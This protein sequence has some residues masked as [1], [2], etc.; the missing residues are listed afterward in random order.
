MITTEDVEITVIRKKIKNIYLRVLPPDGRAVI[1]APLNAGDDVILRFA[2]SRAGWIR[3]QREK[4]SDRY[5]VR[6]KKYETGEEI[7]FFGTVYHLEVRTPDSS[8]RNRVEKDEAGRKIILY[9]AADLDMESRRNILKEWYRSSLKNAVPPV[10]AECE[11]TVGVR[12]KEWR[13]KDMKTRWGTCNTKAARIW[14]NLKLAELPPE[15]LRYVII[16][17]LTHLLEPSHNQRFYAFMDRFMPE[18]KSVKA[19]MKVVEI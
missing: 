11:K 15:C 5:P 13:I 4:I 10:L 19:K 1:T 12:A 14:L 2:E 17:E 3:A 7:L 18:W 16:H 8:D 6:P 9:A